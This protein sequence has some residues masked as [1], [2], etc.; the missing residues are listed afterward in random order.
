MPSPA[1]MTFYSP[2]KLSITHISVTN[3]QPAT[4]VA[5]YGCEM[6]LRGLHPVPR[7][8]FATVAAV[9]TA[10]QCRLG[11]ALRLMGNA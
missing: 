9:E 2:P 5:G 3:G 7:G 6:R 4:K 11:A 8:D 10:G 1:L